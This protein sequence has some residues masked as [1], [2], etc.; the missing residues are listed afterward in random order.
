[1]TTYIS[2]NNINFYQELFK[3]LDETDDD[4]DTNLCQITGLPLT[5]NAR[6]FR[7]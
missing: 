7:M 1:M 2:E 3:G 6:Y 5:T 4:D